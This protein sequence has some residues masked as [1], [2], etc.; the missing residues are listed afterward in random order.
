[1]NGDQSTMVIQKEKRKISREC[2]EGRE[3]WGQE[4]GRG[5]IRAHR[6]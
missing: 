1:M 5:E 3:Q 6:D 2:E 4:I